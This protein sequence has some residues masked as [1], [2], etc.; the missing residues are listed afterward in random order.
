MG[1]SF[2]PYSFTEMNIVFFPSEL[3]MRNRSK[4]LSYSRHS[5]TNITDP[6]GDSTRVEEADPAPPTK[7][8]S[9]PPPPSS[10]PCARA[11]C[12][13][14]RCF[15]VTHRFLGREGRKGPLSADVG[16]RGLSICQTGGRA[17]RNERDDS[18]LFSFCSHELSRTL[19]S[20]GTAVGT[21]C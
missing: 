2:Q 6:F 11:L 13:V 8:A 20:S 14:G 15:M 10:A 9:E 7:T 5:P 19:V 17:Q 4:S 16:E 18:A 1:Q 12:S 21:G 3:F